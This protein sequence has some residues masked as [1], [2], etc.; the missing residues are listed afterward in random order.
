MQRLALLILLLT[1]L[2]ALA[3][4]GD[5]LI[6]EEI[7]KNK[8][9]PHLLL[10]ADGKEIRIAGGVR[11]YMGNDLAVFVDTG[12][13]ES[14]YLP[15]ASLEESK[16]QKI[17]QIEYMSKQELRF[18]NLPYDYLTSTQKIQVR[19]IENVD[20]KKF[21]KYNCEHLSYGCLPAPKFVT[22]TYRLIEI[23]TLNGELICYKENPRY[24]SGTYRPGSCSK[25][26]IKD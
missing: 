14:T 15:I 11:S 5:G 25:I 19:I 22:H 6:I 2:Q 20:V 3:G 8:K 23:R 10:R 26:S 21:D 13:V 7:S 9:T 17:D 12:K 4:K 18:L 1:S 24:P 16:L